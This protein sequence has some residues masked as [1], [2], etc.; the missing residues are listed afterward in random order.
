MPSAGASSSSSSS[1]SASSTYNNKNTKAATLGNSKDGV[2]V[3][4]PAPSSSS[5]HNVRDNSYVPLPPPPPKRFTRQSIQQFHQV[6]SKHSFRKPFPSPLQSQSQSQS[7][8][9]VT[10]ATAHTL[11][12][13]S[14]PKT[15]PAA[16]TPSEEAIISSSK[17]TMAST[18]ETTTKSITSLP[19]AIVSVSASAAA[20]TNEN[21]N[22]NRNNNSS[23]G[24]KKK[25][26]NFPSLSRPLSSRRF[27]SQPSQPLSFQ[28]IYET[29][30]SLGKQL[31]IRWFHSD[32]IAE[33][34]KQQQQQQKQKQKQQ[35]HKAKGTFDADENGEDNEGDNSHGKHE[36]KI[37]MKQHTMPF[38]RRSFSFIQISNI[39]STH[40]NSNA[41]VDS[42]SKMKIISCTNRKMNIKKKEYHPIHDI[43]HQSSSSSSDHACNQDNNSDDDSSNKETSNCNNNMTKAK[44]R[45]KLSVEAEMELSKSI[46]RYRIRQ[47]NPKLS[48]NATDRTTRK[49]KKAKY[50]EY[51]TFS[52]SPSTPTTN[53]SSSS[54]NN[55]SSTTYKKIKKAIKQKIRASTYGKTFPPYRPYEKGVWNAPVVN[56]NAF[57]LYCERQ[58][59]RELTAKYLEY[60]AAR[61]KEREDWNERDEEGEDTQGNDNNRNDGSDYYK[62]GDEM[63]QTTIK[64]GN[65][66]QERI[67]FRKIKEKWENLSNSGEKLY[68]TQEEA[69]DKE[70]YLHEKC[71]YDTAREQGVDA[72]AECSNEIGGSFNGITGFFINGLDSY[73]KTNDVSDTINN[74]LNSGN[75]FYHFVYYNGDEL[76]IQKEWRNDRRC[77]FCSF[78]AGSNKGILT[79]CKT[80]HGDSLTFDGGI[81]EGNNVSFSLFCRIIFIDVKNHHA[82]S[83]PDPPVSLF[84]RFFFFVVNLVSCYDQ[85]YSL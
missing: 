10:T 73:D 14:S 30:A 17:S 2:Q 55:K 67:I 78:H 63:S 27:S 83:H 68:W 61:K 57:E 9:A 59:G 74:R 82:I 70:R 12:H 8:I 1:I 53:N 19:S 64:N 42:S 71:I 37:L 38:L 22:E 65:E 44:K 28:E 76:E 47:F 49:K 72:V 75:V 4:A 62:G 40:K 85:K 43:L 11:P 51:S 16:S 48:H 3:K 46:F 35:Q 26:S 79:H 13:S 6:L 32:I 39:L 20:N 33:I 24:S 81:D 7:P 80:T 69:W 18:A 23:N 15:F 50:N 77:P 84:F 66:R 52:S 31:E 45:K 29:P 54:S 25:K 5:F 60:M 36:Q 58:M 21:R 41:N 56:K 34:M